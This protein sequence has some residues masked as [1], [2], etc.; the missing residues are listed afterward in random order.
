MNTD[1]VSLILFVGL[2]LR[3]FFPGTPASS[4]HPK[5]KGLIWIW[6]KRPNLSIG[7]IFEAVVRLTGDLSRVWAHLQKKNTTSRPEASARFLWLLKSACSACD[8]LKDNVW[9][10]NAWKKKHFNIGVWQDG[11]WSTEL[12]VFCTRVKLFSIRFLSPQE[13][14]KRKWR[15]S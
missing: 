6:F 13:L 5:A 8:N 9:L 14:E 2:F 12:L 1:V 4:H 11:W 15:I 10:H 3:G 7:L